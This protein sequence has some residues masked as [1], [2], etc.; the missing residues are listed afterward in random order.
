MDV[1]TVT[2]K[3]IRAGATVTWTRSFPD[4]DASEYSAHLVIAKADGT[5]PSSS[6]AATGDGAQFTFV[7]QGAESDTFQPGDHTYVIYLLDS[8]SVRTD[9]ESGSIEVL[10][11]VVEG[12]DT[13]TFAEEM[14]DYV[15]AAIRAK[16]SKSPTIS[17]YQI[18][19]Q[20]AAHISLAELHAELERWEKKVLAERRAAAVAAGV[21]GGRT[22]LG[23]FN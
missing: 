8:M 11:S 2:P 16:L 13:R 12:T 17:S 19:D 7:I 3:S 1:P 23:Q 20:S 21:P 6:I 18:R 15:R 10:A 5:G 4:V 9:K 14:R 22:I